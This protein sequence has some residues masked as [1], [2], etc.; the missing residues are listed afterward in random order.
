MIFFND[1]TE[2]FALFGSVRDAT[3]LVITPNVVNPAVKAVI[4]LINPLSFKLLKSDIIILLINK[5]ILNYL[6]IN[7]L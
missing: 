5:K 3:A 1:S 7:L 2:N 6:F 4:Q